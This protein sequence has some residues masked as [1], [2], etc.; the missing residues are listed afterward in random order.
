[1]FSLSS[2]LFSAVAYATIRS[3]SSQDFQ[4]AVDA[5]AN[6]GFYLDGSRIDDRII[7]NL[8]NEFE[9]A[10]ETL[11]ARTHQGE[12]YALRNILHAVPGVYK[13]ASGSALL[14]RRVLHIEFAG[15]DLPGGLEWGV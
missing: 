7:D 14:E 2:L 12:T 13:L 5:I 3:M 11:H 15:C 6:D 10:G 4:Q 8:L 9:T 1:M